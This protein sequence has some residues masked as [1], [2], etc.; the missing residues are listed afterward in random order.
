M[1]GG[2][3]RLATAVAMACFVCPAKAAVTLDQLETFSGVHGWISGAANPNPPVIDVNGGPFGIGDPALKVT[4]NG[5]SGAGGRLVVFNQSLWNGDYMAAGISTISVDL[6][7]L[8]SNTLSFRVAFNGSGGWFVSELR[9]V[10]ANSGWNLREFDVRPVALLNA[11]GSDAD[12]TMSGVTEMRILHS[13]AVDF[14]GAQVSGS[15]MMDNIRAV[16][17]TVRGPAGRTDVASGFC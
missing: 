7:N 1:V 11:G 12:A 3:K 17:R 15:F 5:G 9:Q 10:S 2:V 6:R 16:P 4:S 14:R 13:V 8:G